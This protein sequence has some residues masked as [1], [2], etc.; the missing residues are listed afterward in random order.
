M[1]AE[2]PLLKRPPRIPELGQHV[3][4][5]KEDGS[6]RKGFRTVSGPSTREWGEVVV[7]VATED[8]YRAARWEGRSSVGVPWPIERMVVCSSRLPWQLPYPAPPQSREGAWRRWRRRVEQSADLDLKTAGLVRRSE[9]GD[10]PRMPKAN[11]WEIADEGRAAARPGS[12]IVRA[13]Y[14]RSVDGADGEGAELWILAVIAV[15]TALAAVYS[16]LTATSVLGS[17]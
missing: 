9:R 10:E 1:R 11:R 6:W 13:A 17:G 7:W 2:A 14:D 5:R 16:L 15:L 8:E 12:R 3:N 4:L